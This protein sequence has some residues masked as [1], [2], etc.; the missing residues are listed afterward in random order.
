MANKA[1]L[2]SQYIYFKRRKAN[3]HISGVPPPPLNNHGSKRIRPR[4]LN[5]ENTWNVP[6]H[7]ECPKT[8]KF[9]QSGYK[10]TQQ[11][12]LGSINFPYSRI[13]HAFIIYSIAAINAAC[14]LHRIFRAFI[15]L[16][17][18]AYACIF[19]FYELVIDSVQRT[20]MYMRVK[21]LKISNCCD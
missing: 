19:F 12:Q 8:L 9:W 3:V 16:Y 7:L 1:N 21:L 10:G 13:F 14:M 15:I 17:I 6:K 20:R 5:T 4:T 11:K 2:N 18:A